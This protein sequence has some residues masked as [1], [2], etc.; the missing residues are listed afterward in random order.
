MQILQQCEQTIFSE[1]IIKT[2]GRYNL[3]QHHK[4]EAKHKVAKRR[5]HNKNQNSYFPKEKESTEIKSKVLV[6]F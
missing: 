4:K 6:K 2:L 5:I 1:H 3:D